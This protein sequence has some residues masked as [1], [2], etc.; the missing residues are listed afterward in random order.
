[1]SNQTI[2]G[3]AGGRAT[4]RKYGTAHMRRLSRRGA[5]L[6][7]QALVDKYGTEYMSVI[8]TLGADAVNGHLSDWKFN[9]LSGRRNAILRNG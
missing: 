8:G 5:H 2:R 1:M 4:V 6:G 3:Q 9:R 7:G